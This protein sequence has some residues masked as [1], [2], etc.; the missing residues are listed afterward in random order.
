MKDLSPREAIQHAADASDRLIRAEDLDVPSYSLAQAERAGVV[1]R[2]APGVYLGPRWPRHALTE[3]AAWTLRHP[4]AVAG[5]IT[6]AVH[7]GLTDAFER[8]TWLIVRIGSSPPRSR[9]APVRVI[10]AAP[11]LVD[12]R[13]DADNG[14]EVV[15]VHGVV[16]RVTNPDRTVI[17]LWRYPRLVEGEHALVALRRRI[18]AADFHTA[19]FARLARHMEVWKR[20]EPVLQGMMTR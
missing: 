8:G 2:V 3:A 15:Q 9:V 6:A 1:E 18:S 5:L 11:W 20:I 7:H 14:I 10:Q 12:R 13:Q 4:D 16:V 17:D 19:S